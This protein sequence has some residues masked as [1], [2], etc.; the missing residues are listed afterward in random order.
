[1]WK[2]PITTLQMTICGH[3]EH[4]RYGWFLHLNIEFARQFGS[5]FTCVRIDFHKAICVVSLVEPGY[6][7]QSL[8]NLGPCN[9]FFHSFIHFGV[10]GGQVWLF[11]GLGAYSH[12]AHE[13]V[14]L[15]EQSLYRQPHYRKSSLIRKQKHHLLVEKWRKR[16]G[17]LLKLCFVVEYYTTPFCYFVYSGA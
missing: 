13:S 9:S 3:K 16:S 1:M 7:R 4:T 5:S 10:E 17:S 6:L 15:I 14:L 2:S 11:K 12:I 8:A